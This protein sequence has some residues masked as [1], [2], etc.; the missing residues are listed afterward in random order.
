LQECVPATADLYRHIALL[1]LPMA[2]AKSHFDRA[3]LD[4]LREAISDK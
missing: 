1:T 3:T 4:K 2:E